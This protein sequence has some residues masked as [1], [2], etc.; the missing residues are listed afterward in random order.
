MPS[1]I[2]LSSFDIHAVPCHPNWEIIALV[3]DILQSEVVSGFQALCGDDESSS[4]QQDEGESELLLHFLMSMKEQKQRHASKL[5]EDLG[6]IEAD[7]SELEKRHL[8]RKNASLNWSHEDLSYAREKGFLYSVE[9]LSNLA[10]DIRDSRFLK[11]VAQLEN[12]Y[13]SMRSQVQGS[14]NDTVIR[15]DRDV[16][17]NRGSWFSDQTDEEQQES[18]DSRGAFF[19]GLCKYARYSK[20]EVCGT[21]RNRD[22]ANS[23]NVICS[24]SFDR[25]EDYFAAA[26]VAKKIKIFE[27]QSLYD[28]SVDIHYPV[29]E[30][31]NK[32]KLSCVCWNKYIRNYLASTDFDGIVKVCISLRNC[33]SFV[34]FL[35]PLS[36]TV[37][38]H[39]PIS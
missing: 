21:L 9:E 12:A 16:L 39:L 7:I 10:S 38:S 37:F 35:N 31:S 33:L 34:Q 17:K 6:C 32:S 11:N 4:I 2:L 27:F 19:D 15:A 14:G 29:I 18:S 1:S 5:V 20:L 24:L 28:K 23:T 3:R 22:I 26:G 36:V 13:F 25:D 8:L 30:M